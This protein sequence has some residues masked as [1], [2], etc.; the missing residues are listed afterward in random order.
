[1]E[2]LN[3]F[4]ENEVVFKNFFLTNEEVL[5]ISMKSGMVRGE[6]GGYR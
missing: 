5:L 1:V 3:I 6:K 4:L 2:H